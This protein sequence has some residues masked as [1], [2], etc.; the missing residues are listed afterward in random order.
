MRLGG[1]IGSVPRLLALG[2]LA[3]ALSNI[4]ANTLALDTVLIAHQYQQTTNSPCLIGDESCK[5]GLLTPSHTVFP[6]SV[7][8]Y[9]SVSPVY[10]V[11]TIKTVLGGLT[12]FAVAVDINQ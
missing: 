3:G 5:D 9:D 12:T 8:S 7:S 1:G 11:A 4:G 2:I 6:S 10:T